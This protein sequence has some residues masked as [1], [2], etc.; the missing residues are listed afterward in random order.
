M[1]CYLQL[2]INI[3]ILGQPPQQA[4]PQQYRHP[5]PVPQDPK[6]QYAG[7]GVSILATGEQSL[8]T[9]YAS[10]HLFDPRTFP[11]D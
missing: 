10:D 5:E 11:V 9:L 2:C 8:C 3:L 4:P 7:K 6:S 1:S